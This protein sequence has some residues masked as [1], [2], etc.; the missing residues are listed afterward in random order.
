MLL[1]EGIPFPPKS[2]LRFRLI[3]TDRGSPVAGKT[4]SY[5]GSSL[6]AGLL[7]EPSVYFG[8]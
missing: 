4:E 1:S 3:L 6:Y 5:I 8:L 7:N 2:D